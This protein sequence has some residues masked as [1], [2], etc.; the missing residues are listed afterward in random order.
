MFLIAVAVY[1]LFLRLY[2]SHFYFQIIVLCNNALIGVVTALQWLRNQRSGAPLSGI[3][4]LLKP[5]FS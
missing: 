4:R 2:P 3:F 1:F 5:D